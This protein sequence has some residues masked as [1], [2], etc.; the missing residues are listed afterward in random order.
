MSPSDDLSFSTRAAR[1]GAWCGHIGL[2]VFCFAALVSTSAMYLGALLMLVGT[3]LA[4]PIVWNIVKRD[5]VFWL[6]LGFT[7]YVVVRTYIAG[8]SDPVF[9]GDH[10]HSGKTLIWAFG[11]PFVIV[12][13]WLVA[14]RQSLVI[15]LAVAAAGFLVA[16]G[17]E[18]EW[19]AFF[20]NGWFREV[21]GNNPNLVAVYSGTIAIGLAVWLSHLLKRAHTAAATPADRWYML[22]A[23]AGFI[24]FCLL[25]LY[26]QSRSAYLAGAGVI[27]AVIAYGGVQT[28]RHRHSAPVSW[29]NGVAVL[30]LVI[31]LVG[32]AVWNQDLVLARVVRD[33]NALTTLGHGQAVS[34]ADF[35]EATGLRLFMWYEALQAFVQR[36]WFGWGPGAAEMILH[37][38][39]YTVIHRFSQ[40]HNLYLEL[41]VTLGVIGSAVLAYMYG[42]LIQSVWRAWKRMSAASDALAVFVLLWLLYY[43]ISTVTK[44]QINHPDGMAYVLLLGGVAYSYRLRSLLAR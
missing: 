3:L 20:R 13:F 26:T 23:L 11:I 2:T 10:W 32:L 16:L 27:A 35:H 17:L 42:L 22:A 4:A 38:S 30:V 1:A 33:F 15:Y 31:V 43:W 24:G 9:A 41:L 21:F 7:L 44:L 36:P 25:T 29:K 28:L 40:F 18:F 12:G 14:V 5:R 19:A 6:A 8:V 34:P 39:E 37:K